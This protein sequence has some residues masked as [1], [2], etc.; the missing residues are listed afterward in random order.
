MNKTA[1]SLFDIQILEPSTFISDIIL[2][3]SCF[4]FYRYLKNIGETKTHRYYSN[5]FLF[6][7][8]SGFVGAFAHALFLYTGKL[9]HYLAWLMSG[10][11]VYSIEMSF[12]IGLEDDTKITFLSRFSLVKLLLISIIS[13]IY[14]NFLLVKLNIS[15]GLLLVVS[16]MLIINYYS[17]K[18]RNYLYVIGGI[19][20]AIIPAILHSL[21]PNPNGWMNMND[22]NHYFLI[23][24]FFLMFLGIK[25]LIIDDLKPET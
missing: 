7:A 21:Q 9:L 24:C 18:S 3:I 23:I 15:F 25:G 20:T 17:Q 2:G 4:M 8:M 11:A 6:M 19:F 1:I 5:F 12:Y 22:F 16:P 10:I 13:M 14:M